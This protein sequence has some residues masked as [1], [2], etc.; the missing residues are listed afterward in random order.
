MALSSFSVQEDV[1]IV[2][3]NYNCSAL[4][5]ACVHSCLEQARQVIV[6]DNASSDLSLKELEAN[7]PSEDRLCVIC[8]ERNR[9]FAA[10]CNIGI[11]AATESYILFLNPDCLLGADS[12]QRMVQVLEV[13]SRAGMVGGMLITPDGTEQIGCRRM[14]PTPWRSFVRAFSLYRFSSRWPRL[15]ADFNLY[16]KAAPDGPV[17][18]EAISGACMLVRRDALS[19]VGPLDEGYFLHCEDF[20]WCMRFRQRGWKI[21][22]VPDARV[23]HHQGMCSIHC[24]IFVQWHKHKGMIRFYGKFFRRQYPGVLFW[25]VRFGVWLRFGAV[26]VYY[27]LKYIKQRLKHNRL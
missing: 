15:F 27:N 23:V 10:G 2:I 13:D 25:I 24:P 6:V 26:V 21:M 3:V 16:K 18:V 5:T 7:F 4:L 19:D 20:D 14:I 17:D 22:F 12:L 9:G 1:S 11:S 8:L